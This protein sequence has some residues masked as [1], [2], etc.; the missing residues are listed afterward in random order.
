M[1]CCAMA[2]HR[3]PPHKTNMKVFRYHTTLLIAF[4]LLFFGQ[5][6]CAQEVPHTEPPKVTKTKPIA[7]HHARAPYTPEARIHGVHGTVQISCVV[8]A[9]GKII[10]TK[11]IKGLP[12]GLTENSIQAALNMKFLPA[13]VNGES[14]D[15]RFTLE[16][17]FELL[18][19]SID[20]IPLVLNYDFPFITSDTAKILAKEFCKQA[21]SSSTLMKWTIQCEALG[22]KSLLPQEQE[23]YLQLLKAAILTLPSNEQIL[24]EV[25][26]IKSQNN[27]MSESDLERAFDYKNRALSNLPT[28]QIK[29][30]SAL[31][32]K[33]VRSGFTEFIQ[34]K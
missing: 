31:H 10:E 32:N 7:I 34:K 20:S 8:G 15:F 19:L 11:V 9:V 1:M 2:Q 14:V 5:G 13:T 22:T 21:P 16:F 4:I 17:S 18:E 25:L 3:S 6:I 30:F 33:A 26:L 12:Y 29:R 28:A 24:Y 27:K 23:E